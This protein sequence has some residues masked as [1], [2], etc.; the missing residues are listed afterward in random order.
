M[1]IEVNN[2]GTVSCLLVQN[3]VGFPEVQSALAQHTDGNARLLG[4]IFCCLGSIQMLEPR[5]VPVEPYI[6]HIFS[7]VGADILNA[8]QNSGLNT[9]ALAESP[10]GFIIL[11]H[12]LIEVRTF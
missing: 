4:Q 10:V 3:R 9:I 8:F 11:L 5:L 1:E 12:I 6:G 2:L 7:Q